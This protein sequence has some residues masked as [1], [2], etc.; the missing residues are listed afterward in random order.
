MTPNMHTFSKQSHM[1]TVVKVFVLL[2]NNVEM[3]HDYCT[4]ILFYIFYKSAP[5]DKSAGTFT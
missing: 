1:S 5:E 4:T 3:V 2:F